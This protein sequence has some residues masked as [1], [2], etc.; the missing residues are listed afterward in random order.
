MAWATYYER[1]LAD[2]YEAYKTTKGGIRQDLL[3]TLAAKVNVKAEKHNR[4]K[5]DGDLASVSNIAMIRV[6]PLIGSAEN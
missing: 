3:K 2:N 4:D 1:L 6:L 5:P